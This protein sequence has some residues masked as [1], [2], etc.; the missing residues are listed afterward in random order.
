MEHHFPGD[1][2]DRLLG[3][4]QW[5]PPLLSLH[6]TMNDGEG[7]QHS[8]SRVRVFNRLQS[9]CFPTDIVPICLQK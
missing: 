8:R 4:K 5:A 2:A 1:A 7:I 6:M 9:H 3:N